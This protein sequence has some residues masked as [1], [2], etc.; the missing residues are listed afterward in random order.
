MRNFS[1]IINY[2]K[3]S[4]EYE[5]DDLLSM[6]RSVIYV[7]NNDKYQMINYT[8]NNISLSNLFIK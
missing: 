2:N 6:F 5:K 3:K 1:N 4:Y 7:K 8:Y